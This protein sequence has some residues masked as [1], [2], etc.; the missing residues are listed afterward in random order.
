MNPAEATAVVT[1]ATSGMGR[2]VAMRL[3]DEGWTVLAVDINVEGP[4]KDRLPAAR[5]RTCQADVAD[6]IAVESLINEH[7]ATLPPLRAVVNA[8]GVYPPSNLDDYT[9]HQYRAIFDANVLGTVN[10]TS[11]TVK[12]MRAHGLG[13]TIVNFASADAFS[14][15]PGQLLYS[16]SKAAVVS[17]TKSLAIEL[18]PSGITVNAVAPGWVD[19]PGTRGNDRMAAALPG[20]PLGRAA[21]AEEI[22]DW[23]W[24][25]VSAETSYVT[26]ETLLIAGGAALR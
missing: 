18:A 15:S 12:P 3:L 6:R 9:E 5:H 19:T 1:G 16:A 21:A 7:A 10:V 26:G 2:A 22:A 14:V 8:A 4:I 11:S 17:L 24:K 20:I 25:L 13:G 23:V